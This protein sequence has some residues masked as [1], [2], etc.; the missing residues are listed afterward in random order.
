MHIRPFAT[1]Q[2]FARY[3]FTTPHL[4]S[5]SDCETVSVSELLALSGTAPEELGRLRLGYTES[6][7]NPALREA[8]AAAYVG[9]H[10]D[11]VVVLGSP[12]EGIFLTLHALIGPE[13]EAV[14]LMPAYDALFNV[15]EHLGARAHRWDLKPTEGGWALDWDALPGLVNARTRLLVVNFPHN[16]TGFLPTP[17]AFDRLIGF[18][19]ERG[20]WLFCDEMYRGLELSGA[21]LPS[22]AD[23]VARGV[24]LSG[25]SK[26]HGLPGLRFGWV[27]IRDAELR[28]RFINWKHYTSICP[29]APGEFLALAALNACYASLART[30]RRA[31]DNVARADAFFARWPDAFDWRAPQAG[32]VALVGV[33]APSAERYCHE[34]ARDAGVLLLPGTC[35]GH[36]DTH[37]RFG[38]GRAAFPEALAHYEAYLKA[39]ASVS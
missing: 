19:A 13:D 35:L 29:P 16:P 14:V 26:A 39:A 32:S 21:A 27:V 37:V 11:E 5:V 30:R 7:G 28:A 4:L 36:A 22:A 24:T 18:A 10:P 23:A 38:F 31:R 34:L 9:V 1:E 12:V 25:L 17:E 8:I 15:A 2:F 33:A 3:E 20:L 6:P